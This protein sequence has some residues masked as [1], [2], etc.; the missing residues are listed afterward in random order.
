MQFSPGMRVIIRK[1]EWIVRKIEKNIINTDTLTCEGISPLVKGK[2]AMF[3]ADL[4]SI[5]IVDPAQIKF[6]PDNSPKFTRSR[7]FIESQLRS[8]VPDDTALHVGTQAAMDIL[9]FQLEPA[10]IALNKLKQRILIADTVGLGKTLE[11]GILISELIARGKGQRILVVTVKSMML[12]FQKELWNRFTIPLIR[13][14]SKKIQ[15]IKS[16][17]PPNYNPFFYYDK[18]I[19]SIDTLKQGPS[20]KFSSSFSNAPN[21]R[22]HLENARWDII[23]IDEAQNVATRG[24]EQA[25]RAKLAELLSDK[26]DTLIMLSATPHDG[27]PQSFASL[28]RML[29]PTA[30][31][32]VNNYTKEDVG[33]LCIR[34][35]KKDVIGEVKNAFKERKV[36]IE[37]CHATP[38]EEAA[39]DYFAAMQLKMDLKR[40]LKNDPNILFKTGLEKTLFSSPAACIKSIDERVKKLKKSESPDAISDAR[41]LE[42]LKSL[43]EKIDRKAFSRYVKL[44]ELLKSPKY[45][46]TRGTTDRVV[47]FTER[48]ETMRFLEEWLSEDTGLQ[49]DAV[50]SIHG[51]LSD[52]EQQDIVEKFGLEK[53]PIRILVASDVASEGINLHFLSHRL[54]HFDIPWSLMVFQQRNGRIDR[55]GQEKSPDIRYFKIESENQKIRGDVRILEI[56]IEKEKKAQENLGDPAIIMGKYNTNDEE[57]FTAE[58]IEDGITAED[59]SKKLDQI[60]EDY[61]PLEFLMTSHSNEKLKPKK[62]EENTL[63]KDTDYLETAIKH[64]YEYTPDAFTRME[65]VEGVKIKLLNDL[66]TRLRAVLP[67]EVIPENTSLMLSPDKDF[68]LKE[69]KRS[70]QNSL[71]EL[72]WPATQYLWKLHPIFEWINN[73]SGLIYERG[74]APLIGLAEGLNKDDIVFIVA[75]VISNRKSNPIRSA[76]FGLQYEAGKFKQKISMEHLIE[77]TGFG[78]KDL[79]NQNLLTDT[80]VA[81]AEELIEDVINQSKKVFREMHKEYTED[82]NDLINKEIDKINELRER[83]KKAVIGKNGSELSDENSN[84]NKVHSTVDKTEKSLGKREEA[85]KQEIDKKVEKVDKK[86]DVFVKFVHMSLEAEEIPYLRIIAAFTGA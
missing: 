84:S 41:E 68:C 10:Q 9:N 1:E 35:H 22:V 23:V 59:F 81:K 32:D 20:N 15:K 65:G 78:K 67:E 37:L 71:S 40:K 46:W 30:I 12:Q 5:E 18:T 21:Y 25:Q 75:G 83:H 16:I 69:M 17:I 39:F 29:D 58:A 63:F 55:Y 76:W 36:T 33:D 11:A 77:R 73:K 13:L 47:I 64:F 27:R 66:G 7:L 8:Q 48:I 74:E 28:I 44:I 72:A 80:H 79:P 6:A 52:S 4:E 56:L 82:T 53:S 62:R 14:D 19:I 3:L 70:F 86:F 60:V 85:R 31:P 38:E 54:I 49:K 26:S 34:R 57:K 51:G 50:V 2:N 24:K 42:T 45:N 43:L 61:D